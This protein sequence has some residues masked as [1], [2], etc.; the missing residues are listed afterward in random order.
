QG[1]ID[2]ETVKAVLPSRVAK[3]LAHRQAHVGSQT[4]PSARI[5]IETRCNMR[6]KPES[7]EVEE[8]PAS[9]FTGVDA[10]RRGAQRLDHRALRLMTDHKLACQSVSGSGRND[11]ERGRSRYQC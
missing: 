7:R 2:V 1:A 11:S 10:P 4:A 8:Q 6:I 5:A 9:E 3:H